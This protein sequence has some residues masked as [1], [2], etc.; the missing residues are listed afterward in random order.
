M[1]PL[2]SFPQQSQTF[3]ISSN[4]ISNKT[5]LR[6]FNENKIGMKKLGLLINENR[7]EFPAFGMAEH[8]R[9]WVD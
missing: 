6:T 7:G 5:F 2:L 4:K 3:F 1:Q 8:G 9:V